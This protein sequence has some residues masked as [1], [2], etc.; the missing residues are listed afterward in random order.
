MGEFFGIREHTPSDDL[1]HVHWKVTAHAGELVV[2][3]YEPVRHNTV[4]VYLDLC[5]DNHYGGAEGTLETAVSAAASLA[6]AA[7]GEQRFVSVEGEGL[8]PAVGAPGVGVPHL[9]RILS[10]LAEVRAESTRSFA[11]VLGHR[12]RRARRGG[13][14][15]VITTAAEEGLAEVI[16]SSARWRGA[17]TVLVLEGDLAGV[18]ERFV[19]IPPRAVARLR[20]AEIGVARLR[21]PADLADALLRTRAAARGRALGVA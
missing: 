6:R 21:A 19:Q 3:E 7:L 8:A 4:T 16:A 13:C 14:L 9:Q 1:R 12:L 10:C 17:L 2:K 20:S 11:D 18:P 15:F 5:A